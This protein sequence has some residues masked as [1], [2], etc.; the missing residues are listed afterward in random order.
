[1]NTFQNADQ[2]VPEKTPLTW[3]ALA[4]S[5]IFQV[6]A[7]SVMTFG[8]MAF[9]MLALAAFGA[10]AL[11]AVAASAQEQPRA[12]DTITGV[13]SIT[14]GDTAV[15]RGMR[16]RLHGVDAPESQQLCQSATGASWRCGAVAANS[17]DALIARRPLSCAVLDTDRYGRAIARCAVGDAAAGYTDIGAWLVAN[18]HAVAYRRYSNDYIAYE[19]DARARGVGVWSGRFEY[20]W[21][22]RRNKRGAGLGAPNAGRM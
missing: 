1:M 19:D 18:G 12:G 2:N 7:A 17:L 15:M 9:R 16:I 4:T 6:P 11:G 8:V 3:R 5:V 13:V 10:L 20:P 21:D 22:W 14:D